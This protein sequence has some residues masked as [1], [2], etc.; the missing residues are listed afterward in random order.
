MATLTQ[1]LLSI[2]AGKNPLLSVETKRNILKEALQA[3]V[4]DFIYN[5]PIY[6]RLNFYGGTCLHIVYG[7]NRLSEALDFDNHSHSNVDQ[8]AP[9]L[10][11]H[12]HNFFGYKNV[13]TKVQV[14][15]GGILR[16]TLRF[17]VL[18]ELGL[19]Q[20]LEEALH[21]K[22]ELSHHKQVALIQN[23]PVFVYGRSMVAA[24][25]SLETMMAG[26]ILAC[27]ERSF[28]RGRTGI[29]V[30]GRDYYDLLWFMQQHVWPVEAKLAQDGQKPYTVS[31][32][33]QALQDKVASIRMQDL[34]IDLLPMFESQIFIEAWLDSFHENFNRLIKEYITE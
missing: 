10:A 17:P 11:Q 8:L 1:T 29:E 26:K 5:N 25:F 23:T 33:M 22:L 27:L 21:L 4:L 30:K 34:S 14:G 31:S 2:L 32:A 28:M 12:F 3:Y 24:H 20:H 19:S 6:R 7:L 13:S 15:T 16:V 18:Y 9:D